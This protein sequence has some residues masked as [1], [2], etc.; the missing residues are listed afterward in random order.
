MLE[1]HICYTWSY[2]F[3]IHK[4]FLNSYAENGGEI[5]IVNKMN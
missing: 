4:L 1:R 5:G 2:Y 3:I